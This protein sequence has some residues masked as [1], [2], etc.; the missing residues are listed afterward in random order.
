MFQRQEL[1]A[2]K[3]QGVELFTASLRSEVK[4]S[5]LKARSQAPSSVAGT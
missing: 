4:W 3:K 1:N 2:E 5:E